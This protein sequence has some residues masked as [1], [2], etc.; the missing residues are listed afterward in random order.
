MEIE[1]VAS[2]DWS[3]QVH[4]TYSLLIQQ[5]TGLVTGN[6]SMPECLSDLVCLDAQVSY[7]ERH[8]LVLEAAAHVKG[9][10]RSV[11]HVVVQGVA[12]PQQAADGRRA[13][14]LVVLQTPQTCS[15]RKT[16]FKSLRWKT[17]MGAPSCSLKGILGSRFRTAR[18]VSELNVVWWL[19]P[20]HSAKDRRSFQCVS[21][22]GSFEQSKRK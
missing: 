8:V 15:R 22:Y 17:L 7:H 18:V 2:R 1:E 12:G 3:S 14:E 20:R 16:L 11:G 5:A 10:P 19:L 6:T 21:A 9:S 4:Q 13:Q